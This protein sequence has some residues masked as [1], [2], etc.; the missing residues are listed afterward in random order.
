MNNLLN[1]EGKVMLMLTK[2]AYSV[3]LN[4]LWFLCCLPI[5]TAGASTTALFYVTLKM[6]KDEEG[7]VTRSFF[8]AFRRNFRKATVIWLILLALGIVLALDGYV[9]YHMRFENAFWALGTA[10]FL[11]ALTAYAIVLMYIFPLLARFENTVRAMFLNSIMLGMRFLLC[12]AAMAV[13]YFVMAFVVI[14][15]FTPAIIFGEGLCALLCS[16]LLANIL[17]LCEEKAE[18]PEGEA[19]SDSWEIPESENMPGTKEVPEGEGAP[20]SAPEA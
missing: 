17:L 15:V 3:Y 16:H 2:I 7:N 5:V 11:V 13:I 9:F 14:S 6:A 19:V 4:I 18:R 8:R 20:E 1:P 12:T 10:V